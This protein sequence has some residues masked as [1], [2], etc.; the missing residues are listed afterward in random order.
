MES[1]SFRGFDSLDSEFSLNLIITLSSHEEKKVLY[2]HYIYLRK[3]G[4]FAASPNRQNVS[5]SCFNA[6]SNGI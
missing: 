2:I 4:M 3:Q 1:A 6:H 5:R